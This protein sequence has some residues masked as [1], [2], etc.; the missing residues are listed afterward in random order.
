MPFLTTR[1]PA[2]AARALPGA[3]LFFVAAAFLLPSDPAYA[4]V[5]YVAVL[6]PAV[7]AAIGGRR[8][9]R[10]VGGALAAALILWSGLTLLWGRDDGHRATRF[11]VDTAMTLVFVGAALPVLAEPAT[12]RRLMDV[13]VWAGSANAALSIVLGFIHRHHGPRLYGWGATTHPILGASVMAVALLAALVRLLGGRRAYLAPA[14]VMAAFVLLTE[15]RGPIGAVAVAGLFLCVASPRPWRALGGAALLAAGLVV[16]WAMLPASVRH[17]QA[18]I[19]AARGDSHRFEIW[20]RTLQMVGLHPWLG[21]GLAANLDLPGMTFPHDLYLSVLFYSGAVGFALFAGLL[22]WCAA[23]LWRCR[24]GEDWTWMV[25]LCI[26][27]LLAGLTDLGQIT[28]GPSSMWFIFW[29]PVGLILTAKEDK[30]FF[31]EKKKQKTFLGLS[32]TR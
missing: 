3:V 4:L 20:R 11:A 29:L 6:P 12:R 31:F 17:H 25:S 26:A 23:R 30:A 27:M 21:N 15:S 19:M 8:H 28:K 10:G 16:A 1:L 13:L 24:G 5:F 32:R 22:G 2:M 9:L 18:V 14:A 7:L